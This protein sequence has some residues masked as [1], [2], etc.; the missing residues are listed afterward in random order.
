MIDLLTSSPWPRRPRAAGP[1]LAVVLAACGAKNEF[2]PPPPP[3]V[4]VATPVIRDVTTYEDFTGT[5]EAVDVVEIRA[6]VQGILHEIAYAEGRP[7]E[8]GAVLFR[9]EKDRF[10][11]ERDAALAQVTAAETEARQAE[12]AAQRM[13]RSLEDEAVSELQALEARAKAATAAAA[14][15]VARSRLAIDELELSYTEVTTPIAGRAERSSFAVG[16]LVGGLGG[17]PLTRI[18]DESKIN[19]W[20]SVPDRLVQTTRV[21]SIA[22]GTASQTEYPEV[23]L[24]TE[25]DDGWP[26]RGR[27]DYADP[28]VDAETGTL[29]IRAVFD[30]ATRQLLPG[31]FV[32]IRV[33]GRRLEDALLVPEEAL[34]ADQLGRYL[35]V[36][37]DGDVVERRAV[38]LGPRDGR[39]RVVLSGVEP[40]ER[41]VV[42]GLL[43]AR[44]G[45]RVTPVEARS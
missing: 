44:P 25:V 41:I 45:A 22:S 13:E 28:A 36:V 14:V 6:R 24:R 8:A 39:D 18:H 17:A 32:R 29:R 20:F 9:I 4:T 2:Q 12:V 10:E 38:E 11:A 30:N 5:T 3:R 27:I 43:R 23:E 34:G 33:A 40:G 19:V 37:G 16:S 26:H 31:L 35:L 15:E 7:V 21:K 1:A 42:Q